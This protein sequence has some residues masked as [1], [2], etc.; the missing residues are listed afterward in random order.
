M[1]LHTPTDWDDERWPS[2][3]E[4]SLAD[5]HQQGSVKQQNSVRILSNNNLPPLLPK[6]Q[7]KKAAVVSDAP[8][9]SLNSTEDNFSKSA[10]V[11]SDSARYLAAHSRSYLGHKSG[12]NTFFKN[13]SLAS[14]VHIQKKLPTTD[15][16]APEKESFSQFL[17]DSSGLG[18][19]AHAAEQTTPKAVP[20]APRKED[21]S[22]IAKEFT[23]ESP[24]LESFTP[25]FNRKALPSEGYMEPLEEE[26]LIL[27]SEPKRIKL[28]HENEQSDPEEQI[29]ITENGGEDYPE[30][31]DFLEDLSEGINF[32]LCSQCKRQ[33]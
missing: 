8:V 15:P 1:N 10:I 30:N 3:D 28:T 21:F 24:E 14:S 25:V 4:A 9:H 5:Q 13:L 11:N 17:G 7:F 29:L 16:F 20:K 33:C 2:G 31:I 32:L 18:S 23:R 26:S 6:K 12:E 22:F 27:E 19:I